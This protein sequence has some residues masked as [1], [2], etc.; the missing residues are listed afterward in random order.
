MSSL[1]PLPAGEQYDDP[2]TIPDE[3]RPIRRPI[4]V[5]N[6]P[7]SQD[8]NAFGARKGRDGVTRW[9]YSCDTTLDPD[10]GR[11][12]CPIC[13]VQRNTM[14]QSRLRAENQ[15][16]QLRREDARKIIDS[17]A[18]VAEAIT[19]AVL[20]FD[21]DYMTDTWI[22]ELMLATKELTR[23]VQMTLGPA[24]DARPRSQSP[25]R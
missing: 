24:L 18:K 6:V 10:G 4:P 25:R 17:T 15:P 3:H 11:S 21:R 14:S 22:D 19:Q 13:R 7:L 12:F 2:A 8:R 23:D 9:C 16:V 20:Q 5:E 1:P